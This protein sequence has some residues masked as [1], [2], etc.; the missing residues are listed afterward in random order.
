MCASKNTKSQR[1]AKNA[2]KTQKNKMKQLE[3]VGD[4]VGCQFSRQNYVT[5]D[6]KSL[7]SKSTTLKI[8]L[9]LPR[10]FTSSLA[11]NCFQLFHLVFLCFLHFLLNGVI[12]FFEAHIYL[13]VSF[14]LFIIFCEWFPLV[15][16][17]GC[18][19]TPYYFAL[20]LLALS[21]FFFLI[22]LQYID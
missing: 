22:V 11:S 14:G 7:I 5:L 8:T 19:K 4:T 9:F 3:T 10:D 20:P 18:I 13:T 2:K 17:W 12:Y 1:L 21:F 6:S 15:P 16:R